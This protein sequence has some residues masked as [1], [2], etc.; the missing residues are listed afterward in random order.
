[1]RVTIDGSLIQSESDLHDALAR[2][3]DF[4][5]FYGRNLDALWDRLSTDVERPIEI[6]WENFEVSKALLGVAACE[7]ISSVLIR[8]MDQDESFG[9]DDKL[10]VRFE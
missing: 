9:L 8:V 7:K 2:E 3:L 5:P 6:L 4:G 1:M 10:T